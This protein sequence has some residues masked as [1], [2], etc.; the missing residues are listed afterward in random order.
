MRNA[1]LYQLN[2]LAAYITVEAPVPFFIKSYT[3]TIQTNVN[4]YFEYDWANA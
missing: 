1:V 4:E 2:M 3:L